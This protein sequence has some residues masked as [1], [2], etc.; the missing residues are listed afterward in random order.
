MVKLLLLDIAI[1]KKY[2][3]IISI[4]DEQDF[5]PLCTLEMPVNYIHPENIYKKFIWLL[6]IIPEFF[7]ILLIL[8]FM[9]D[10][11]YRYSIFINLIL[12]GLSLISYFFLL[13]FESGYA[14][15][16]DLIK[17]ANGENP[18]KFLIDQNEDIK[19]FCPICYIRKC[20]NIKHCFICDKCVEGF[21]HHCFWLNKCIGKGNKISYII[22]IVINLFYALFSVYVSCLCISSDFNIIEQSSFFFWIKSDTDYNGF[23]I[24]G[25]AFVLCYSII[26]SFPLV[27]LFLIQ[28][29]KML[30]LYKKKTLEDDFNKNKKNFDSEKTELYIEMNQN[31]ELLNK[32]NGMD[33]K[34]NID[35]NNP[36]SINNIINNDDDNEINTS[37]NKKNNIINNEKDDDIIINKNENKKE[38]E[39][40]INQNE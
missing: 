37:N 12:F 13:T 27:F 15:N 19:K 39:E 35:D 23:R 40:K 31:E 2:Y 18:L 11:E 29:S 4:L 30:G 33:E 16:D 14:K 6:I 1:K 5:N 24:L 10:D 3:K 8:P 7:T 36:L 17:D 22:F 32:G 26:L 25:S 9:N 20:N 21:E 34:D 38:E 28:I